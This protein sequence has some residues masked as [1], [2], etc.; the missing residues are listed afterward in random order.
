MILNRICQGSVF[1]TSCSHISAGVVPSRGKR[2][3]APVTAT[4]ARLS[5]AAAGAGA[6]ARTLGFTATG[7]SD[8]ALEVGDGVIGFAIDV[9]NIE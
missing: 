7:A 2:Q 1:P 9:V 3:A 4:A 8:M 5:A 6:A